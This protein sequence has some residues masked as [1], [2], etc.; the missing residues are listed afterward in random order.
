MRDTTRQDVKYPDGSEIYEGDVIEIDYLD[1]R[2]SNKPLRKVG[3]IVT[4]E[5]G[6]YLHLQNNEKWG[7]WA[8]TP[9]RNWKLIH[10]V[11]H[12]VKE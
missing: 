10:P 2:Y 6:G 7:L 11:R 4:E 9:S 1:Y 5:R 12:E 8:I 3:I